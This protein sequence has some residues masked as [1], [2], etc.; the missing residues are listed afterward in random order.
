MDLN[1]VKPLFLKIFPLFPIPFNVTVFLGHSIKFKWNAPYFGFW[2]QNNKTF[3]M[4][5]LVYYHVG[6]R[7]FR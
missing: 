6:L 3:F 1:L 2:E 5:N 7:L 4:I